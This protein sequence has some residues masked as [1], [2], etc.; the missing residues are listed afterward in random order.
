MKV[1]LLCFLFVGANAAGFWDS[2]HHGLANIEEELASTVSAILSP[3]LGDEWANYLG[4]LVVKVAERAAIRFIGK[5]DVP[6]KVTIKDVLHNGARALEQM[7]DDYATDL[8]HYHEEIA[9]LAYLKGDVNQ[10]FAEMQ[11]SKRKDVGQAQ[12]VEAL[13]TLLHLDSDSPGTGYPASPRLRQPRHWIPC[14]TSTSSE[15]QGTG[16]PASP[17]LRQ[18]RHW[19]PC[20][21]S[22]QTAKALDTL[23]YLDSDSPGAGYPASPLLRQPRYWIPC[24]TST[25]TA[26]A[27]DTRLH[28]DSDSPGAGY[29]ASPRLSQP[30]RWIP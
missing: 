12:T 10:F 24:F 29:P 28:L 15:S 23:L 22:T 14:F 16:Y 27:L 19:I 25:H 9:S 6:Q 2:L 8:Q 4:P 26:Q 5:R 21:T 30:R 13:D 20:F 3:L 18:P 17:L 1:F 7:F 11:D